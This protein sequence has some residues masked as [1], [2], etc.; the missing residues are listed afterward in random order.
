MEAAAANHDALRLEFSRIRETVERVLNDETSLAERFR[1]LFREQ[2]VTITS[3]L[4][5]LGIIVLTIVL[6]IQNAAEAAGV[7]PTP[8][9]P[10]PSSGGTDWVKKTPQ[11]FRR[12]AE[13]AGRK[14][15]CGAVWSYWCHRLLAPYDRGL[16]CPLAC[17]KLVGFSRRAG[18]RG[19]G[20][21][22]DYRQRQIMPAPIAAIVR[23]VFVSS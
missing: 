6:A 7:T 23:S 14:S 13:S 20:F 4:A 17:R 10:T 22:R 19:C 9:P 11:D 15:G 21:L 2:G 5:A 16:S 8:T 18:R 3:I 1:T 12:L